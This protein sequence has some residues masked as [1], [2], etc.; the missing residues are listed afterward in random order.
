MAQLNSANPFLSNLRDFDAREAFGF[1]R[2]AV[3]PIDDGS[4]TGY[5]MIK[6]GPAVTSEETENVS[7]RAVEVTA[8]WG[9]NVIHVAHLDPPR[10]F[11]VGET[12]CDMTMPAEKIGCEKLTLINMID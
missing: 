6:N 11:V 7:A 2:A 12:E 9:T 8:L 5:A 10:A 4:P 3:E 1:D